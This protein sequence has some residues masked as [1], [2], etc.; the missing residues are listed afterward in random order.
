MY[1]TSQGTSYFFEVDS[2]S[3]LTNFALA[4]FPVPVFP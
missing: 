1:S 4:V 3:W 2:S